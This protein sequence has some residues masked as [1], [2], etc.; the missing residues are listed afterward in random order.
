MCPSGSGDFGAGGDLLLLAGNMSGTAGGNGQFYGGLGL[1]GGMVDLVSGVG[2]ETAGGDVVLSVSPGSVE[3]GGSI[4]I[5]A[6][7]TPAASLA[8]GSVFIDGGKGDD[9]PGHLVRAARSPCW[10]AMPHRPQAETWP[11]PAAQVHIRAVGTFPF[12]LNKARSCRPRAPLQSG[13]IS[14]QTGVAQ[15]G[16]SGILDVSTGSTLGRGAGEL[17]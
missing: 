5:T 16:D 3:A 8:G 2:T 4:N 7:R 12:L 11:S 10:L 1:S 14:L 13:A 6:G 9:L 17:A 15:S